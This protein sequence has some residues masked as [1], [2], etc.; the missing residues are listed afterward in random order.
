MMMM[1]MMMMVMMMM[2]MMTNDF[3][4]SGRFNAFATSWK[5]HHVASS[6]SHTLH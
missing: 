6:N 3:Q 2:M 4:N 5:C 1:M